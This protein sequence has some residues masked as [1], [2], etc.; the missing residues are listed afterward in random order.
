MS[1][2]GGR[3]RKRKN[4]KKRILNPV[5]AMLEEGI[6][7]ITRTTLSAPIF[8]HTYVQPALLR[9]DLLDNY[10]LLYQLT[11]GQAIGHTK[12][13]SG[14]I[15]SS[16]I[17][18]EAPSTEIEDVSGPPPQTPPHSPSFEHI[19]EESYPPA[20]TITEQIEDIQRQMTEWRMHAH[21]AY[22]KSKDKGEW[23]Y[24]PAAEDMME[25]LAVSTYGEDFDPN[26]LSGI[27][28]LM[29]AERARD[30][31][32]RGMKIMA[33]ENW[34]EEARERYA[35][36]WFER[37]DATYRE[38]GDR[39]MG[40]PQPPP[41]DVVIPLWLQTPAPPPPSS[42]PKSRTSPTEPLTPV[43]ETP[44]KKKKKTRPSPRKRAKMAREYEESMK[45]AAE[46][47]AEVKP[48]PKKRI[49]KR[50]PKLTVLDGLKTLRKIGGYQRN[51]AQRR[52]G[53]YHRP[54]R[55]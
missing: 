48:A 50:T 15:P 18:W 38:G 29:F 52:L 12:R 23:D 4:K 32:D 10:M 40:T 36:H 33:G 13:E 55:D 19:K 25:Q 42:P 3:K 30:E 45:K 1:G 35:K 39:G 20:K 37:R 27:E 16:F 11:P 34:Q 47:E 26:K 21:Q 6:W 17:K 41:S 2:A 24:L 31:F 14:D 53:N 5:R 54:K 49:A 22:S 28:Q 46:A 9:K 43:T 44:G 51:A 8:D 7:G